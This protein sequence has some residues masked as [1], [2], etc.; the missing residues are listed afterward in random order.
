MSSLVIPSPLGPLTLVSN[1][2]AITGVRFGN[3]AKST[4]MTNNI[5]KKCTKE[6]QEY[7][8]G[9]RSKFSVAIAPEST[10]FQKKIWKEISRVP[11][12]RTISYRELAKRTG[13]PKAI[14][15]AASACGKNPIVILLPCHR[16]I[17]SNG[18]FGGY[19][20]GI[21]RK[22]KLLKLE[23]AGENTRSG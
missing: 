15:A 8:K 17:A 4:T 6:L 23:T 11:S 21:E 9:L 3:H 1:G 14:R 7:F 16:I 20:G 2:T 18:G 10:D 12:G 22:K 5:L 13:R 19:S